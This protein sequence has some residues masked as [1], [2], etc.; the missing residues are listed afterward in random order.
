MKRSC[1]RAL[2][3]SPETNT[4]ED[5]ESTTTDDEVV[6]ARVKANPAQLAQPQ[7]PSLTAMVQGDLIE[8]NHAVHEAV[9]LHV[10]VLRRLIVEQ[11]HGDR[12][13][14]KEL[15]ERQDLPSETKRIACEKPHV[16]QG[17]D[18]DACWP[19]R[20]H[21]RKDG[22]D[23]VLQFHLGWVEHGVL[24]FRSG[25]LLRGCHVEQGDAIERPCVRLGH[26][27]EL[28]ARF[29]ER[30]IQHGLA[31]MSPLEQV[32]HGESCLSASGRAFDEIETPAGEASTEDVVE[33]RN[34][35]THEIGSTRGTR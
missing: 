12:M 33:A 9:Q 35:S 24:C 32:L 21:L 10:R 17:I 11:E 34:S 27:M 22:V 5:G 7:L 29:R 15:L 13:T 19:P 30:H 2:N 3:G 4:G 28:F 20:F 16:R 6:I 14:L 1:S 26:C 8:A 23:G 25:D 31:A 18:H